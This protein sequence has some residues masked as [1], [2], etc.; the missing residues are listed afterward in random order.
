M[1]VTA[2]QFYVFVACVAFGFA[3]GTLFSAAA[4]VKFF[5][6]SAAVRAIPDVIAFAVA[7]ALY[8]KFAFLSGF[9]DFRAYMAAGVFVGIALYLKSLHISLAKICKKFY[10]IIK[11]KSRAKMTESKAKK[12]IVATTVGAVLLA[13]ILLLLLVYQII[14]INTDRRNVAELEREIARYEELVEEGED[15]EALR[16][17]KWWIERRARELGYTYPGDSEMR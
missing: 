3:A 17:L 9:P 8:V 4:L 7:A 1:F 12:L 16:E 13:A 14:K 6:K 15:E 5:F 2:G 11:S 10:N